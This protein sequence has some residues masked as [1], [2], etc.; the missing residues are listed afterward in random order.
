[1]FVS[2]LAKLELLEKRFSSDKAGLFVLYGDRRVG[3]TG[4]LAHYLLAAHPP[5]TTILQRV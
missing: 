3:K 2:R 5:L 4:L 1:M